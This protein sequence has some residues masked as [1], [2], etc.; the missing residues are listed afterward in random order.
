[1]KPKEIIKKFETYKIIPV[2]VIEDVKN[3]IP[4]GNAL[5][6]AGLPIVEITFRTSAAA[7]AIA[8]LTNKVPDLLVGAGTVLTKEQVDDAIEAGSQFIVTPGFNPTVVDYCIK[9][10]FFITPGVSSPTFVEWALERGLT[11]LKF[12]PASVLGGIKMLKAM[13]GP[14]PDVKFIPTGGVNDNNLV[15]YLKLDNVIACGGSW[16]VNKNLIAAHNFEEISS[17]TKKAL[18]L[19]KSIS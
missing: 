11:I 9:K 1:V 2:A 15:E 4:L 18:S 13:G 17:T 10:N 8:D 3:A 16:I 5:L 19:I 12:F 7:K 6:D 14:Y